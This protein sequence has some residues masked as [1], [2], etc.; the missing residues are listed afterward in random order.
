M[1]FL[2][3]SLNM[4]VLTDCPRQ[5]TSRGNPTLTEIILLTDAHPRVHRAD[6]AFAVY[7]M[8]HGMN[9][10]EVYCRVLVPY[11]RCQ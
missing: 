8:S 9:C 6:G 4:P 2:T 5:K 3:G 11:C 7:A 10:C 1:R